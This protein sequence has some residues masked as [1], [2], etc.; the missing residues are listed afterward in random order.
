MQI[1]QHLFLRRYQP[2]PTEESTPQPDNATLAESHSHNFMNTTDSVTTQTT[3]CAEDSA[4]HLSD[5]IP[6]KADTNDILRFTFR[7]PTKR[8]DL[9]EGYTVHFEGATSPAIH[10]DDDKASI[11]MCVDEFAKHSQYR[12]SHRKRL[13]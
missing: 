3:E 7:V 6:A 8:T 12:P 2:E 10:L 11:L 1:P 13:G 9:G 5:T 4:S